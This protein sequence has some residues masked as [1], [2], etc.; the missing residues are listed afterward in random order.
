[1]CGLVEQLKNGLPEGT[2]VKR[3]SKEGCKVPLKNAPSPHLVMDLDHPYFDL[4]DKTHCDFLFISCDCNG[5]D[6]W[7]MPLELKRGSPDATEMVSQLQAGSGVA[8]ARIPDEHK[9]HSFRLGAYRRSFAYNTKRQA[10]KGSNLVSEEEIRN[11][12]H[13]MRDSPENRSSVSTKSL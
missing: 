1:M 6:N 9:T 5:G 8:E 7:V 13:P 2:I 11:Q 4:K 3:C 12:T 10:Q